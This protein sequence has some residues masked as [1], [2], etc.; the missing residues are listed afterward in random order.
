MRKMVLWESIEKNPEN[1]KYFGSLL[2]P[3]C[4]FEGVS[5]FE[6]DFV[7]FPGV[8]GEKSDQFKLPENHEELTQSELIEA[9][10]KIVG[11]KAEYATDDYTQIKNILCFD[12]DNLIFFDL[13]NCYAET[14]YEY[15][16]NSNLTTIVL[17]EGRDTS[18][19]LEVVDDYELDI[20]DGSNHYYPYRST[21]SHAL[22]EAV[23]VDGNVRE[24]LWHEWSQWQGSELDTGFFVTP[25]E[26][27]EMLAE[28]PE[29]EE[30]TEW[31]ERMAKWIAQG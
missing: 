7:M 11:A 14:C 28:H 31:V 23:L 12:L 16:K 2:D 15:V 10:E 4:I 27:L 5:T 6:F 19:E 18:Y 24:L 25:E 17:D 9:L 29:I 1:G 22:L 21:G 20:W 8:P 26:A 30:I 3:E 13:R